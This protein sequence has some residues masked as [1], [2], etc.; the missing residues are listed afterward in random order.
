MTTIHD[1]QDAVCERYALTPSELL[2]PRQSRRCAWPRHL[3]MYLCCRYTAMS[4]SSIGKHFGHRDHTVVSYAFRAVEERLA[5]HEPGLSDA[6]DDITARLG[7][8]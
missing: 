1:I 6:I 7:E 5:R 4:N 8:C 2:G 3:A